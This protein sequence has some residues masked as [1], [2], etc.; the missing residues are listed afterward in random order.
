MFR[1]I[2]MGA[3]AAAFVAAPLAAQDQPPTL[4]MRRAAANGPFEVG[5]Y[6]SLSA[7]EGM[8]QQI[9]R[10]GIGQGFGMFLQFQ[11]GDLRNPAPAPRQADTFRTIMQDFANDLDAARMTLAQTDPD[12][13]TAFVID[14]KELWLDVNANGRADPG[15]SVS[16][17][18]GP[19]VSGRRGRVQIPDGPIEVRFD[20]ADHAW[21]TA[22][23]HMLSMSA[24]A[25][26]AF[27]PTPVFADLMAAEAALSDLPEIPNTYDLDAIRAEITTLRAKLDENDG[28]MQDMQ[29]ARKVVQEQLNEAIIAQNTA[30]D[31]ETKTQLS[32]EVRRLREQLESPAYNVRPLRQS[33]RFLNQ[34]LAAANAKLPP[35]PQNPTA[36]LSARMAEQRAMQWGDT[37]NAVYALLEVLRQPPDKDRIARVEGHLRG[38]LSQN[39]LFWEK[40]VLETDDDH[41]WVPNP[42]QTSAMG[43]TVDAELAETWQKILDDTTAVL[44][45]RLLVPH[46]LLSPDVGINIAAWFDDPSSLDPVGWIHGRAAYPYL[47]RGPKITR[48]NWFA[49]QRLTGGNGFLFSFYL[50]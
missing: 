35:D 37:R 8:L 29:A 1:E 39:R 48:G 43:V 45:G 20:G 13:A 16:Q 23:T 24:E 12:R 5:M 31:S 44:D 17:I 6:Q 26:L 30:D 40:V 49:L 10:Y 32:E 50:N 27:D 25:V 18:I 47:A 2:V 46:P 19:A 14:I 11:T 41:E 21:L 15:E 28:K 7:I 36:D 38:M 33:R 9:Y 34:Q 4:E 3:V 42:M 22:Y